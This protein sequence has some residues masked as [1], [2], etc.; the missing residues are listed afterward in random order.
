MD[1]KKKKNLLLNFTNTRDTNFHIYIGSH[2]GGVVPAVSL[3]YN[4]VHIT[5]SS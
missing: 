5:I 2:T 1:E 3:K 4:Y